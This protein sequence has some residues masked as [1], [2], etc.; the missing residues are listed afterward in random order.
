M[1][2]KITKVL[3]TTSLLISLISAGVSPGVVYA[4]NGAPITAEASETTGIAETPE[5]S[6][7]PGTSETPEVTEVPETPKEAEAS[8]A[9]EETDAKAGAAAKKATEAAEAA[10]TSDESLCYIQN[11]RIDS[12]KDGTAPF[13]KNN[14]IGNDADDENNIVRS[15]DYINYNI[16]YTTGL[17]DITQTVDSANVRIEAVLNKSMKEAEFNVETLNWCL[18]RKITYFYEDGS[19]STSYDKNKNVV[20]QVL[21]G[22]RRL[23]NTSQVNNIPGTGSLTLGVYVKASQN[24]SMTKPEV[25]LW[26]EGNSEDR[27]QKLDMPATVVSAAPKYNVNLRR[28]DG[29]SNLGYY[30]TDTGTIV[31]SSDRPDGANWHKGRLER[32]SLALQ[33]YND[34]ADKGLKGIEFPQGDITYD[35]VMKSEVN[36]T[37]TTSSNDFA[38]VLWDYKMN[39]PAKYGTLGRDMQPRGSSQYAHYGP[40]C[41]GSGT[42]QIYNA[43]KIQMTQDAAEENVYHVTV[44]DYE[45]D[46][47]NLHF[48]VR[49]AWSNDGDVDYSAN[50]GNF[51]CGDVEVLAQFPEAVDQ[52]SNVYLDVSV[53]NFKATSISDNPTDKEVKEYDNRSRTN[54]YLTPRGS[55]SK[56]QRYLG[57]RGQLLATTYYAGD[58]VAYKGNDIYVESFIHG[59]GDMS[60]TA[61]NLLQKIDDE[62]IDITGKYDVSYNFTIDNG[63]LNVLYGAKKD[64][65]GWADDQEMQDTR[66]EEL[67]YFKSVED[68]KRAGYTCVAILYELR[69]MKTAWVS[70]GQSYAVM[71]MRATVKTDSQAGSVY[72]AVSDLRAWNEYNDTMSFSYSDVPYSSNDRSYGLVTKDSPI[73]N[74]EGYA[75][76]RHLAYSD[77]I[78]TSYKDG[79]MSG[80]NGYNNGNSLLVIGYKSGVKIDISDKTE[81]ASGIVTQKSV[82]DLDN[83]E[84]TVSYKVSPS[85]KMDSANN[86]SAI[87]KPDYYADLTVK[88]DIPKGLTYDIG[89]A[90]AAPESVVQNEDGSQ[91]VTWLL[92]NQKV[93]ETLDAFDFT[94]TIGKAGTAED[95]RNNESF[96]V[97]A[98]ISG[99]EDKRE[100]SAANGNLS[101]VLMSVIRLASTSISKRAEKPLAETGDDLKYTL[102]YS[103]TSTTDIH[104]SKIADILPYNNDGRG[105]RYSGDYLVKSVAINY[106]DAQSSFGKKDVVLAYSNKDYGVNDV[107]KLSEMSAATL[108]LT[109]RDA[110]NR[111]IFIPASLEDPDTNPGLKAFGLRNLRIPLSKQSVINETIYQGIVTCYTNRKYAVSEHGRGPDNTKVF[112][113]GFDNSTTLGC[114]II[115]VPG[116]GKSTA[117]NITLDRYPKAIRHVFGE[118]E[119]TQIPVMR[120]TAFA[121][122][123]ITAMFLEFGKRLDHIM[124]SGGLFFSELKAIKSNIG[125]M[126]QKICEYIELFHIGCWI[127]EEAEFFVFSKTSKKSFQNIINIVQETGIFLFCTSNDDIKEAIA[128]NFRVERRLLGDTI[129]MNEIT[130]DELVVKGAIQKMW[131]YMLPQFQKKLTKKYLD[132]IYAETLGSIDM[133]SILLISLQRECVFSE[134]KKEKFVLN[135]SLIKKISKAKLTRMKELF[136]VT[137]IEAAKGYHEEQEAFEDSIRK[138]QKVIEES[139]TRA[140]IESDIERGYDH[141]DKLYMVKTSIREMFGDQYTV[142]QIESAFTYCEKHKDGFKDMSNIKMKQTVR[143]R[144][145]DVASKR[146]VETKKQVEQNYD[147]ICLSLLGGK[148]DDSGF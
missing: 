122:S 97:T 82:Y 12:V 6:R 20:K 57:S 89:S 24:G 136:T 77:Y 25:S 14:E 65:T 61:F 103:N 49:Y 51:S 102:Y 37:D 62:A 16:E 72:Q 69:D 21:T 39:E 22:Y 96:K 41:N 4:E 134:R 137:S 76:T 141:T 80:H 26:I 116:T 95:V 92:K 140:L 131:K 23:E 112:A 28:N 106:K 75:S 1:F 148:K 68:L 53:N 2:K 107:T 81:N 139:I 73:G 43:G 111:G 126:T 98:G 50:I 27:Y 133:V 114:S 78:K 86:D 90:T 108:P 31:S 113:S 127:I 144:L 99:K 48:P 125:Q 35:L 46:Y 85:L 74:V 36:G 128:S 124:D 55:I 70:S 7:T 59:Y 130:R 118:Y 101:S 44:K 84:R 129:D 42:Y 34:S 135:E 142:K 120:T 64:K 40:T 30:N 56:Y 9:S 147:E 87:A 15:F 115:G 18:D 110:Y 5:V 54:I 10:E 11:A 117:I 38:P 132:L 13:D 58:N 145:E 8:K 60:W 45:F 17:I 67:V 19:A 138:D 66:E 47:E 88:V 32:Y 143:E 83:G 123:N 94:C 63:T 93:G 121:D 52:D 3:T 146:K 33:L 105:T 100:Q 109:G 119:Y 71:H 29:M 104:T 79:V 91:T